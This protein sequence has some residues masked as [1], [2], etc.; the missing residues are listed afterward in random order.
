MTACSID[1]FIGKKIIHPDVKRIAHIDA[2]A[3]AI[4]IQ[5]PLPFHLA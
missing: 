4:P 1:T 5:A 2:P 3:H